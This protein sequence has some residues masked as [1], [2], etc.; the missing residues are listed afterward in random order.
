MSIQYNHNIW[1]PPW[2]GWRYVWMAPALW[3]WWA[4]W[5]L[6]SEVPRRGKAGA[7]RIWFRV[8]NGEWP[9]P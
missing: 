7:W 4:L 3:I 6:L 2:P 8:V 1:P 5:V 9:N